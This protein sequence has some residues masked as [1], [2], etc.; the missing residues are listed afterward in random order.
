MAAGDNRAED[1]WLW[2]NSYGYHIVFHQYNQSDTVTGGHLYSPDGRNWTCSTEAVYDVELD[3]SNGTTRRVDHRER[4]TLLT[5]SE[6]RPQWLITGA[7][8]GSKSASFP[9]C[10]SETVITQIV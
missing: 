1:P 10:F 8:V 2:Q 4:P 6:G 9:D 7:E 3:F 5:N